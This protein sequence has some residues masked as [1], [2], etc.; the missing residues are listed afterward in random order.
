MLFCFRE[1]THREMPSRRI[2]SGRI[3]TRDVWDYR[4]KEQEQVDFSFQRS[5]SN[6][7]TSN[8]DDRLVGIF[9]WL[10]YKLTKGQFI[11][12]Q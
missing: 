6:S 10:L 11:N 12:L 8:R 4:E 2:G 5:N 3:L 7:G 9:T 1:T